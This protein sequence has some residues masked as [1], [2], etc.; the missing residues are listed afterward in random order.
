MTTVIEVNHAEQ[1]A[2]AQIESIVEIVRALD[3][4]Q[5]RR[6]AAEEYA[7][8]LS[9][10]RC[11]NL[12]ADADIGTDGGESIAT[13]REAVVENIADETI[14]PDDFS[15]DFEEDAARETIQQD[16]LSVQVRAGWY[17]PGDR[18]RDDASAEEFEILLCTGGPAVRIVGELDRG[19]PSRPRIQ[20]QDWGTP[21][22]EYFPTSEQ[23]DALQT[24][25]EQ[26][27]YGD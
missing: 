1:Q 14:E 17:T 8:G 16:P 7:K 26:F 4:E 10:S 21:W 15:F 23:R 13:L 2:R 11:V 22:T 24:Y 18:Q 3:E 20:Y 27:Y 5:A 9:R 19:E 12:L 6:T 25:C